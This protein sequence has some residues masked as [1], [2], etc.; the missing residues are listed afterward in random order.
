MSSRQE[1]AA[2]NQFE[3]EWWTVDL[4]VNWMASQ[5]NQCTTLRATPPIGVLQISAARNSAG[6]VQDSDLREFAIER[7]GPTVRLSRATYKFVLGFAA[8][9]EDQSL[10]WREWWLRSGQTMLYVT[11]NVILK[12]KNSELLALEAILHSARTK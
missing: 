2:T 10:F 8:E 11:Y 4:P 9:H 3:S 7:L 6:P 5:V 12:H 1:G